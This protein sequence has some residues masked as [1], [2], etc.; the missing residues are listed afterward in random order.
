MRSQSELPKD[1]RSEESTRDSTNCW[2]AQLLQI[3]DADEFLEDIAG[4]CL[5]ELACVSLRS[6]DLTCIGEV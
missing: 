1:D 5:F 4:L 3:E 6:F 2:Q